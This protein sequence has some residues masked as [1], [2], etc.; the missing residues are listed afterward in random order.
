MGNTAMPILKNP[1]HEKFAREYV[2][3]G[4]GA[5]AY[6]RVYPRAHPISTARVCASQFL[7][8]PN[9]AS[10]IGELRQAMAKRADITADKILTDYQVALELAKQ[11]A[12]PDSIVNAATAQAKLVGL[13]RERVETGE[14]GDFDKMDNV[15]D[16]LEA[17]AKEAGPEVASALSKAF[18]ISAEQAMTEPVSGADT[19][20]Q[21]LRG[22][23]R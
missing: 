19:V 20:R 21:R 14:T 7:T 8:K 23:R 11:Q 22:E 1:R 16:I 5:E 4:I 15:S 18:G 10:R 6:R 3:T 2:K 13:L 9:I 17:V 12:K